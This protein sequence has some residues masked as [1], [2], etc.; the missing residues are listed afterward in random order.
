VDEADFKKNNEKLMAFI[1][2]NKEKVMA[3]QIEKENIITTQKIIHEANKAKLVARQKAY[4]EANTAKLL[5]YQKS[6]EAE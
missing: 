1:A 5:A 2:A 6:R 4:Q 3:S